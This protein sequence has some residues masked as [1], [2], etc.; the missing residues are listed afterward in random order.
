MTRAAVEDS[1][2][3][4]GQTLRTGR[5]LVGGLSFHGVSGLCMS[6]SADRLPGG[7]RRRPMQA[8]VSCSGGRTPA[9]DPHALGGEQCG[10]QRGPDLKHSRTTRVS[11]SNP[12]WC[13]TVRCS[14]KGSFAF[15]TRSTVW[16]LPMVS[17]RV[18]GCLMWTRTAGLETL[19]TRCLQPRWTPCSTAPLFKDTCSQHRVCQGRLVS[20]ESCCAITPSFRW[21]LRLVC[22]ATT[23]G[24]AEREG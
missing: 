1:A 18:N 3:A 8:W 22:A 14:L 10:E 21:N 13:E 2:A 7:M 11:H 5:P 23:G 17:V 24:T 16:R 12:R 20:V 6:S 4:L 15:R 9:C 19:P